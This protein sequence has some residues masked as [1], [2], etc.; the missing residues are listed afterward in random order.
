MARITGLGGVFF[1][2]RDPK[3]LLS[4]YRNHLGLTPEPESDSAV[5]EW[6]DALDPARKGHTV[7]AMFRDDSRYFEPS[8]KS[9]MVN[10]RV[11]DLHRVLGELRAEGIQV[12]DKV[13]ESE[14]GRFGWIMD[15]EGNRIE[16]W[17]PPSEGGYAP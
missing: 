4:W 3:A 8:S 13:E 2:A 5:F 17:E 10:F 14:F 11:A 9:F 1:K 15:P 12:D 16:L 7:F 6:R